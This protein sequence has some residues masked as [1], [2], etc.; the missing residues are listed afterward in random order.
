MDL[1]REKETTPMHMVHYSERNSAAQGILIVTH[2]FAKP[3]LTH[4]TNLKET[5]AEQTAIPLKLASLLPTACLNLL[6]LS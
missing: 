6:A 1:T 5:L 2:T 3:F 4:S